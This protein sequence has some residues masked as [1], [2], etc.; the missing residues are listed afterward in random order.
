MNAI[1]QCRG[2]E[3]IYRQGAVDVPALRGVDLEIGAGWTD[4]PP[5]RS[6]ST[7]RRWVR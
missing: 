2:V 6:P 3:K 7:A 4:P 5:A 1:I